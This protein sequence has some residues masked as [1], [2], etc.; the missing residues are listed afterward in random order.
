MPPI[1]EIANTL[2]HLRLC[3]AYG[4]LIVPCWPSEVWWTLLYPDGSYIAD[5]VKKWLTL[6]PFFESYCEGTTF[7]GY[8]SIV[9]YA[10]T[11]NRLFSIKMGR[12]CGQGFNAD[13]TNTPEKIQICKIIDK[14]TIMSY[15]IDEWQYTKEF[16]PIQN[17]SCV[18]SSISC[19]CA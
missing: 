17:F 19:H 16:I 7:N 1:H 15:E 18:V 5:F 6:D 8:Q 14:I 12:T 3:E 9:H 10:R 11:R 4:T 2:K 13:E